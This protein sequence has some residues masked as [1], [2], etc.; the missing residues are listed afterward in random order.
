MSIIDYRRKSPGYH[1]MSEG[2]K[3]HFWGCLLSRC[4]SRHTPVA[5]QVFSRVTFPSFSCTWGAQCKVNSHRTCQKE[6][7]SFLAWYRLMFLEMFTPVLL[8][9]CS[10]TSHQY[11]MWKPVTT[12]DDVKLNF[13]GQDT[14]HRL[15][16]A[17]GWWVGK[18]PYSIWVRH[19]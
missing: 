7:N 2:L 3:H 6:R 19:F 5:A 4:A 18:G 8:F 9:P 13:S 16:T 17:M 14:C 15:S 12:T 11:H 1:S 10:V